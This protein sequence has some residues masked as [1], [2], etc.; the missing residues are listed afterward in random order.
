MAAKAGHVDI[1]KYLVENGGEVNA[2][3]VRID[4][5]DITYNFV[6]LSYCILFRTVHI[7][8]IRHILS[9]LYYVCADFSIVAII[10]T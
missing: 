8:I 1:V 3:K 6:F 10:V 5:Y 2:V 7:T 4:I 9:F